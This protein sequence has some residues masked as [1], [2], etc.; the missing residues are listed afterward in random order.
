MPHT[1]FLEAQLLG[2]APAPCAHCLH[3][4]LLWRLVGTGHNR[5]ILLK[6]QVPL[7]QG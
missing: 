5:G 2:S 4:A 7:S 3:L 1:F 6:L